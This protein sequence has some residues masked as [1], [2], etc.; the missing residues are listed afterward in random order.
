MKA[1]LGLEDAGKDV[2]CNCL[3]YP[4]PTANA[5]RL[6]LHQLGHFKPDPGH[7]VIKCEEK[8]QTDMTACSAMQHLQFKRQIFTVEQR[9]IKDIYT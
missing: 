3:G 1:T 8:I 4:C 6:P 9:W 2:F 7:S 5:M